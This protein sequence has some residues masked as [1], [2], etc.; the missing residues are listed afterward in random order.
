LA[1]IPLAIPATHATSAEQ[2][3]LQTFRVC[4][5]PWALCLYTFVVKKIPTGLETQAPR[6]PLRLCVKKPCWS[7]FFL[8]LTAHGFFIS[9]AMTQRQSINFPNS[10]EKHSMIVVDCNLEIIAQSAS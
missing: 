3:A 7:R 6:S 9:F 5:T 8:P 1:N 4:F 10:R 2:I